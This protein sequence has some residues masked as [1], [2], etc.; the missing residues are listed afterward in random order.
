[1]GR[2]SRRAGAVPNSS[3]VPVRRGQERQSRG[4]KRRPSAPSAG[5][6]PD[7]NS[8]PGAKGCMSKHL[9]CPAFSQGPGSR[10]R[11]RRSD[12]SMPSGN[13][14]PRLRMLRA[15]SGLRLLLHKRFRKFSYLLSTM[16][17]V[18]R[19]PN[20]LAQRQ[21][22]GGHPTLMASRAWV[23]SFFR[24]QTSSSATLHLRRRVV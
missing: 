20:S 5:M 16:H 14:T 3:G 8:F 19:Q 15:V 12:A 22:A 24:E 1:M 10:I 6:S 23:S 2:A 9:N 21:K 7:L 13:S 4:S 11:Q 17:S 18:V